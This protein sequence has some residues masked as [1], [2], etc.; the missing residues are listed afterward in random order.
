MT[1]ERWRQVQDLFHEALETPADRRAAFL[2]A[3]CSG[4]PDLRQ[5]VERML[6]ADAAASDLFDGGPASLAG[7]L[8][9]PAD[10]DA[11]L[12]HLIAD[13]S[14]SMV[15]RTLAKHHILSP[16]G[17]G[18]MGE[19]YL[20]RDIVLDR[21]VALKLLPRRFTS[22]PDR[23]DRFMREAKA[24]SALNH[25][26]ILTIYE[27][28]Q[29]DDTWFIATEFVEGVSLR[30]RLAAGPLEL[31]EAIDLVLQCAAALEAAH[32]AGIIHRYLKPENVM[33]RPDGVVK[34]VDFGLA[35]AAVQ[36]GIGANIITTQAGLVMGTPRYMSPEQARG[37]TVDRRSDIYSLTA[38]LY[39]MVVG[40]P[41]I[42]GDTTADVFVSLLNTAAVP[43]PE[44]IAR[45]PHSR[46]LHRILSRGAHRD[47]EAR[48]QTMPELAADLAALRARLRRT[49]PEWITLRRPWQIA[50]ALVATLCAVAVASF[51]GVFHL[52]RSS[53]EPLR[54][55]SVAGLPRNETSSEA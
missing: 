54:I 18:S 55:G 4:D 42:P 30:H 31:R 51:T 10:L 41:L 12:A 49:T 24:A 13:P 11:R 22:D 38:V 39:E 33:I 20:A 25:P 26:N 23:I 3:S 1:P 17:A 9:S 40:R 37:E 45:L 36:T 21:R 16:I 46:D 53:A 44:P 52:P 28:G 6:A 15:G 32:R 7:E 47:R 48:Y 5:S 35:R 29:V 27:V 34:V 14:T 43:A 50:A 19:V 2:E 8:V